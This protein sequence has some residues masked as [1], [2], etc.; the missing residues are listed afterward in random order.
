[1]APGGW[2]IL[3]RGRKKEIGEALAL[4]QRINFALSILPFFFFA[5][6][7]ILS[8]IRTPFFSII[9]PH[10]L[11]LY[12]FSLFTEHLREPCVA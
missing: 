11:A 4:K 5:S 3:C 12:F 1:M 2:A 10:A 6:I 8:R 7:E 9:D